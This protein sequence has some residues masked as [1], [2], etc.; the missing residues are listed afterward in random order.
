MSRL[1]NSSETS[2]SD[3]CAADKIN[4]EKC[5]IRNNRFHPCPPIFD[6]T[7]EQK[8]DN[9]W[10]KKFTETLKLEGIG[11]AEEKTN[12]G[13]LILKIDECNDKFREIASKFRNFI[14]PHNNISEMNNTMIRSFEEVKTY[15]PSHDLKNVTA[16]IKKTLFKKQISNVD[17]EMEEI[18]AIQENLKVSLNFTD[19]YQAFDNF[20]KEFRKVIADFPSKAKIKCTDE[21]TYQRFIQKKILWADLIGYSCPYDQTF[22][23]SYVKGTDDTILKRSCYVP[24]V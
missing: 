8:L 18:I 17:K 10:K 5:I 14:I 22:Y 20:N 11:F 12:D 19:Y 2:E 3:K 16:A 21:Q 4:L 9:E 24:G 7:D 6:A 13:D 23:A 15:L 1:N